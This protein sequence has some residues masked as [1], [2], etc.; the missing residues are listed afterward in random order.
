MNKYA[1]SVVGIVLLFSI[2][3]AVLP[4]G[5]SSSA[6][7]GVIRLV[8]VL[9]IIA[10]II[11]FFLGGEWSANKIFSGGFSESV[12]STDQEF[13]EYYSE[14]RVQETEKS[15]AV[16]LN[17]KYSVNVEVE[18]DWMLEK[19]SYKEIYQGQNIKITSIRVVGLGANTGALRESMWLYL[20]ENYCR[21]VLIE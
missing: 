21:E 3:L 2:L 18:I 8:C 11:N 19:E 16:E 14:T 13:I 7:K 10:P 17:K 6:I 12:I 15:L 5:K 9:A 1:L 20:T 4:P